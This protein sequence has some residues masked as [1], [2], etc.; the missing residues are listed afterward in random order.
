[1]NNAG[2]LGNAAPLKM[3]KTPAIMYAGGVYMGRDMERRAAYNEAWKKENSKQYAV[4]V[5]NSSGIPDALEKAK[6]DL[7]LT[8]G[9]FLMLAIREKLIRDGYL[10]PEESQ[11]I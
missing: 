7:N 8:S 4:R 3:A 6:A 10:Q 5:T 1:M 9:G 11:E 2:N